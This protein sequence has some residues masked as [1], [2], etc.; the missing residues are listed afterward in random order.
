MTNLYIDGR[1]A[2]LPTDTQIKVTTENP[3]FTDAG[4][5][6][7]EVA[8]P[9]EGCAD[10][11]RI[12]GPI[13][14]ADVLK[15]ELTAKRWPFVLVAP[16][17]H[18]EGTARVSSVDNEGVKIQL[19]AGRSALNDAGKNA[20]GEDLYIDELHDIIT[21]DERGFPAIGGLGSVFEKAYREKEPEADFVSY[22]A[23][24]AM[25]LHG[26]LT[27]RGRDGDAETV[28]I[29]I[30]STADKVTANERAVVYWGRRGKYIGV[31][32]GAK[33]YEMTNDGRRI[34]PFPAEGSYVD[35]NQQEHM[36]SD[37]AFAPQPFL[38]VVVERLLKALG[39]DISPEDNAI[40]GTWQ[41]RI[42]VANCRKTVHIA[43]M[44]PHWTVKE[45]IREVQNFFG[46]LITTEGRRA[47]I[48]R[49]RNAYGDGAKT[50]LIT[51]PLDEYTATV[52]ENAERKDTAGANVAYKFAEVDKRMQLPED[53]EQKLK[54]TI[55]P[56]LQA[57]KNAGRGND[58]SPGG[59]L[60]AF[61]KEYIIT[62]AK[63]GFRH[64]YFR[65]H[66]T[67]QWQLEV[68]DPMGG[69]F[70]NR[71]SGAKRPKPDVELRIVPVQTA[72][73]AKGIRYVALLW[74]EKSR[75][76]DERADFSDPT[77]IM[78]TADTVRDP[79]GGG[80]LSVHDVLYPKNSDTAQSEPKARDVIE[81]AYYEEGMQQPVH[82]EAEHPDY[83]PAACG[84]PFYVEQENIKLHGAPSFRLLLNYK[85]LRPDETPDPNPEQS[86][87]QTVFSG[88][89]PPDTAVQRVVSFI[90]RGDFSPEDV[91]IIGGR[92]Y[93]CRKLEFSVTEKG[94]ERLVKGYFHEAE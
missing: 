47:R 21:K 11:Q 66:A 7:L 18:I 25:W 92:R 8:L 86:M 44:L 70:P 69:R 30:Y 37:T 13:H 90:D 77:A 26:E 71:K 78:A 36:Q 19:L 91:Y 4:T 28:V 85:G 60:Y 16:P 22:Y 43:H 6:T 56:D 55:E 29:P 93:L 79:D 23:V 12:F 74:N 17:L 38:V 76:Y 68:I 83:I 24:R 20:D 53:M 59:N 65:I 40:R 9:L 89:T 35:A 80:I 75:R 49:K 27:H 94:T 1:Q 81:V 58:F 39:F 5:Y 67:E 46:V 54:C 45:F 62:N 14:R 82:S 33:V 84:N 42:I 57:V 34:A 73:P 3:L 51:Q 48:V 52:E 15:A 31:D 88:Y 32:K 87:E 2:V 41:E 64:A 63:T 10:N 72:V 50:H 61:T